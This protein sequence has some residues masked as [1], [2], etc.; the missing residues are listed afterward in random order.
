MTR[1]NL[2]QRFNN[3]FM[4]DSAT[5]QFYKGHAI[6]TIGISRYIYRPNSEKNSSDGYAQ[7][8]A[9]AKRWINNDLA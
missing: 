5:L 1:E 2:A 9:E 4:F 8:V 7:S 3:R 6:E